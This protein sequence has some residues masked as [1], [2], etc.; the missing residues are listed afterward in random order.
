M[1]DLEDIPHRQD[2]SNQFTSTTI[3]EEV[4]EPLRKLWI[5]ATTDLA[6]LKAA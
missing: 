4:I 6:R 3:K 5:K 2:W 1:A